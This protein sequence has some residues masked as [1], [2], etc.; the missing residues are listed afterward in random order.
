MPKRVFEQ[1]KNQEATSSAE[2]KRK[3]DYGN[4]QISA[5]NVA[6]RKLAHD[7]Y[8]V[9]WICPLEVEQIAALEMLDEEH[10]VW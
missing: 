2:K 9:G 8:T 3:V 1:E 6:K 10:A 4:V 7:D 5:A